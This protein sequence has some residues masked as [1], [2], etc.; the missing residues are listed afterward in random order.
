LST[1]RIDA[2]CGRPYRVASTSARAA[3]SIG[4]VAALRWNRP[5]ISATQR[6]SSAF[7]MRAG[8]ETCTTPSTSRACTVLRRFGLRMTS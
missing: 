6:S 8:I 2:G 4:S 7:D 5:T 1:H 3:R